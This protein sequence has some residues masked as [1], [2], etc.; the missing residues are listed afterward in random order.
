MAPP[1]YME[2]GWEFANH[3]ERIRLCRMYRLMNLTED[4]ICKLSLHRI[5]SSNAKHQARLYTQACIRNLLGL[6]QTVRLLPCTLY[7]SLDCPLS[8]L[9]TTR[10]TVQVKQ[11]AL[12]SSST[13][14]MACNLIHN[15]TRSDGQQIVTQRRLNSSYKC[16]DRL[17]RS[18]Y[19]RCSGTSHPERK[20]RLESQDDI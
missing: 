14:T 1:G 7:S 4:M 6:H 2:T 15:H 8:S 9:C 18:M 20:D 12:R 5:A 13:S 19:H 3:L 16:L 11:V 10:R 17:F